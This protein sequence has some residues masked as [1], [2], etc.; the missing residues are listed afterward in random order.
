MEL[1][2]IKKEIRK[3]Y[4]VIRKGGV[5]L[6]PTDTIWGLGCDATNEEAILRI[7]NIKKREES[8]SLISLVSNKDQLLEITHSIPNIDLTSTPTTII[9]PS[10]VKLSPKL[11]S[12]GSAAIRIVKD[13][14]CRELINKLNT[15][16][17]STSANISGEKSPNQFSEISHD[18]INNVDYIVNLRKNEIMSTPSNIIRI[19][20][21][22]STERIR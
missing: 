16:I 12:N 7:F 9:Y 6:Y 2:N 1:T 11:L 19:M 10:V 21:D 17:V 20:D 5:I 4:D 14:F 13:D 3:A 18:I 22:G 8:K 15:P